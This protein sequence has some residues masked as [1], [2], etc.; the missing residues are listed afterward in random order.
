MMRALGPERPGEA[1]VLTGAAVVAGATLAAALAHLPDAVRARAVRAERVTQLGLAAADA[2]LRDAGLGQRDGTPRSDVAV[3]LGTAFGCFLTNAEHQRRL[4][5]GGPPAVSPRTFAATVSNAATGEITIAYGLAGPAL[6]LS[7]GL[8]SGLAA[9]VEG[10][11]LLRRG[12]AAAV[13]AGGADAWGEPLA[14]WLA[15]A[16]VAAEVDPGEGAALVV[17]ERAAAAQARGARPIAVLEACETGFAGEPASMPPLL[18]GLRP[19]EVAAVAGPRGIGAPSSGAVP[20]AQPWPQE[21][22][23]RALPAGLGERGL[24]ALLGLVR[25]IPTGRVCVAVDRCP[26]GHVAAAALRREEM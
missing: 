5:A 17:L 6:T 18:A 8:A 9:L 15:D 4:A 20:C 19:D 1:I 21:S 23:R 3:V 16:G 2:A 10:A 14:R 24:V 12:G 26:A 25:E 13:L 22:A 7:A 11:G